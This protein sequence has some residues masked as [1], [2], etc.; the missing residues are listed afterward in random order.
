MAGA[1]QL[2]GICSVA[3]QVRDLDRSLAF[4]RDVLGLRLGHREGRIAQLHGQGDAPPT[5]VLLEVGERAIHQT[6]GPGLPVCWF[7]R[8]AQGRPSPLRRPGNA[9]GNRS[10]LGSTLRAFALAPEA[11]VGMRIP[12][13]AR[14]AI[15][16]QAA[17]RVPPVRAGRSGMRCI[18]WAGRTAGACL[19]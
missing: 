10:A 14:P 1:L 19:R 16:V 9:S 7:A 8:P 17:H 13:C 12:P 11:S 5:L 18:H 3:V 15:T 4:Y 2:T 6:A